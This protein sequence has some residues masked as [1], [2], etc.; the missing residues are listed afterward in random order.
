M[1]EGMGP[2]L[3]RTIEHLGTTDF[4]IIEM[5]RQ[6]LNAAKALRDYDTL[7]PCVEHPEAFAVRSAQVILPKSQSWLDAVGD[8]LR[9]SERPLAVAPRPYRGA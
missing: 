2:V 1:T 8:F 9:V 5:R 4:A 3:D 6:V 7:P